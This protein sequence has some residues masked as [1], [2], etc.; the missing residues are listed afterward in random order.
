[1]A[2]MAPIQPNPSS[3]RFAPSRHSGLSG[4]PAFVRRRSAFGTPFG[5]IADR[6]RH[7]QRTDS[8]R[9]WDRRISILA[10]RCVPDERND[11][12]AKLSAPPLP[13]ACLPA[14]MRS[15][16][17]P[18]CPPSA[19]PERCTP[20]C[21]TTRPSNLANEISSSGPP[22]DYCAASLPTASVRS[23]T[24]YDVAGHA[25][26]RGVPVRESRAGNDD[27]LVTNTEVFCNRSTARR[28]G[29]MSRRPK[30]RAVTASR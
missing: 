16:R 12:A 14:G 1:M 22:R 29:F 7:R 28:P 11:E 3:R 21:P 19:R 15:Q 6:Q 27:A 30:M 9:W 26:R 10:D 24:G 17:R 8:R 13:A 2:P 4:P 23:G 20:P 18:E 25:S 5:E